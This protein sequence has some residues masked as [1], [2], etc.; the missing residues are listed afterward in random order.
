MQQSRA[1]IIAQLK[2]DVLLQR[3]STPRSKLV[4]SIFFEPFA[5]AF[6]CPGFPT[7]VIHEFICQNDESFSATAGFVSGVL[8]A[9]MK[10]NGVVVW[11]SL[12]K[13]MFPPAFTLYDI[14]ADKIIFISLDKPKDVIWTMEE[15]LKCKG[16]SAVVCDVRELSFKQSRRLQLAT[17]QSGVT[18]FVLRQHPRIINTTACAARWV[19][20]SYVSYK[21]VEMPG[22]GYPSWNV[23]LQKI[24]N[25]KPAS[26]KISYR[27]GKF[28]HLSG[29]SQTIVIPQKQA[30]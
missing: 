7:G 12:S 14:R 3:F 15:A 10:N 17:E 16:L 13:K 4:S 5:G 8:S 24:K 19:I 2:K 1:D 22:V 21:P 29:Q 30:V 18:G 28:I 27:N 23:N 6:P 26:W 9:L 20:D 11:I 25:G